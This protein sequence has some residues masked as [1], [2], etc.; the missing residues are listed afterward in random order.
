MTDAKANPNF[1]M[2]RIYLDGDEEIENSEAVVDVIL[3]A[4]ESIATK[5]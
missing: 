4:Y 1:I 3:K 2:N 5:Q